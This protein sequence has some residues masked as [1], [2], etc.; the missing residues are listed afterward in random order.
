[1]FRNRKC[2]GTG[3]VSAEE[4]ASTPA[5][6]QI[7]VCRYW[8]ISREYYLKYS[9]LCY[10]LRCL[11]LDLG[12]KVVKTC[13][14]CPIFPSTR[15]LKNKF[16][17]SHPLKQLR[18]YKPRKIEFTTLAFFG[19]VEF[20]HGHF[21]GKPIQDSVIFL[22][23]WKSGGGKSGGP[24][25]KSISNSLKVSQFTTDNN[26]SADYAWISLAS[27]HWLQFHMLAWPK[28]TPKVATI[29]EDS[30]YI[31][32]SAWKLSFILTVWNHKIHRDYGK[33]VY[34]GVIITIIS[35]QW[36]ISYF[37][38]PSTTVKTWQELHCQI[39][40]WQNRSVQ[41][42]WV[43]KRL[44]SVCPLEEGSSSTIKIAHSGDI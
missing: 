20:N 15:I 28:V 9:P 1:M 39:C 6:S 36:F 29:T 14:S 26:F 17:T 3:N 2:F 4:I 33:D 18:T 38:H 19:V 41:K 40:A 12:K 44:S 32:N 27:L 37:W 11:S 7:R 30:A 8:F 10:P 34:P 13:Q 23:S 31:Y 16:R 35:V 21:K 42:C 43:E 5:I 25:Y 22:D 24:H